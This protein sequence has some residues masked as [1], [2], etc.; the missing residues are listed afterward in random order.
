DD[1]AAPGALPLVQGGQHPGD[2][3]ARR[4]DVGDRQADLARRARRPRHAHDARLALHDRV[5]AGAAALRP[6]VPEPGDRQDDEAGV[7]LVQPPDRE[8]EPVEDARPEVLHEHVG[9]PDQPLQG[10]P[11]VAGL[12]VEG[13]R[14]LVPVDRQVVGADALPPG[15]RRAPAAGLVPAGL[16]DLDHPRAEVGERHRGLRARHDAAEVDDHDAFERSGQGR[17]PS[18]GGH[19]EVCRPR[20][21]R[22]TDQRLRTVSRPTRDSFSGLCTKYR[23]VMSPSSTRTATTPL[24]SA[25]S[26]STS[27]GRPLSWTG[28]IET[29]SPTCSQ[30]ATSRR[31]TLRA[32]TTGRGTAFRTPPPS[33]RRTT[34]G[35]RTSSRPC[36]SPVSTARW[37]ALRAAR[38]CAGETASRGRRAATCERARCAIWR[39]AA[40][41]LPTA[42]AISP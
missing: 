35:A 37:N 1:R 12:Q 34:S 33:L 27:P 18:G 7:Q 2:A 36:R 21:R 38:V 3:V 41:F 31:A 28:T 20:A 14:L 30:P 32:P 17:P 15:E 9:V 11:A 39:T 5:V 42:S 8:A 10:V 19:L 16:L 13:D 24:S 6:V 4:E 40:R 26:R 25:P 22:A 29:R 23:P